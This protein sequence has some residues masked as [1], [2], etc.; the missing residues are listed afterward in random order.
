MTPSDI[1]LYNSVF[2]NKLIYNTVVYIYCFLIE[3][4]MCITYA[5]ITYAPISR[6]LY[7]IHGNRLYY[8]VYAR[9]IEHARVSHSPHARPSRVTFTRT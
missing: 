7:G 6:T 9:L 1:T 4:K 2:K 5:P 3:L 8:T